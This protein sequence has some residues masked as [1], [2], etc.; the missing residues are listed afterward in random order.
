MYYGSARDIDAPILKASLLIP[1]ANSCT[2]L[3]AAL[4]VFTFLGHVS[5]VTGKDIS[6]ISE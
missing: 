1:L 3:Y 2:S 6:E 5:F 4:T